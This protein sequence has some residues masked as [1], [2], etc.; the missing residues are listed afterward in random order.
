MGVFRMGEAMYCDR[1]GKLFNTSE[2]EVKKVKICGVFNE[3]LECDLCM[4]CARGIEGYVYGDDL[5][6]RRKVKTK[7]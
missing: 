7:E 2:I 1:C 5:K 3:D 4:G 6:K